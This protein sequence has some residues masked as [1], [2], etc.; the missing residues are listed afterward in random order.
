[1]TVLRRRRSDVTR[2]LLAGALLALTVGIASPALAQETKSGNAK[3][4]ATGTRSAATR[5]VDGVVKSVQSDGFVVSG[6]EQN[7]ERDWAFAITDKT[8]MKQGTKQAG[9]EALK[10]GVAVAVNYIEQDGKVIAQ[11]VTVKDAGSTGTTKK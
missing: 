11:S 2:R 7:K 4:S 3:D 10:P 1:M 6:K 9:P 5:R 8:T